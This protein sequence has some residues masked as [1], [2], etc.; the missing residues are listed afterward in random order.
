M[1]GGLALWNVPTILNVRFHLQLP[2]LHIPEF[3]FPCIRVLFV[4]I[5][6][7]DNP[8][9]SDEDPEPTQSSS[10]PSSLPQPPSPTPTP[11]QSSASCTDTQITSAC[12]A[13]CALL[14]GSDSSMTTDCYTTI[15][16]ITYAPCSATAT[17]STTFLSTTSQLQCPLIY[18]SYEDS[19]PPDDP[20]CPHEALEESL[21]PALI[22]KSVAQVGSGTNT[23][24]L[25]TNLGLTTVTW[26][27]VPGGGSILVEDL[28][29]AGVS[30]GPL[31]TTILG[32]SRTDLLRW[33][34]TTTDPVNCAPSVVSIAAPAF[35]KARDAQFAINPENKGTSP[36]MDHVFEKNWLQG[37]FE[38]IIDPNAPSLSILTKFHVARKINCD[39]LHN[40]G[41]GHQR[42][43]ND[44]GNVFNAMPGG[45]ANFLS[46][47]GMA[48]DMNERSKVSCTQWLIPGGDIAHLMTS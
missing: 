41:F 9:T 4:N 8:P 45:D 14:W 28:V 33:L 25:R 47:A 3:S 6:N 24:V 29:S 43:R 48:R 39:D 15:C 22:G 35:Q 46:L 12:Q 5:G 16:S 2:G 27:W 42:T 44:M 17:T 31:A 26:P 7:C 11:T 13:T 40:Y 36:T 21:T 23:C 10:R 32:G 37:F 1:V 34:T 19:C 30:P 20:D 38:Y 18:G